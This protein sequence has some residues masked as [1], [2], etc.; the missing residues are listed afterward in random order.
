MGGRRTTV[1]VLGVAGVIAVAAVAVGVA[2]IV[3]FRTQFE[4]GLALIRRMNKAVFNPSALAT[5]GE[6][7]AGTSVVE[8]VG[9][10]SGSTYRTPIGVVESDAGYL[11]T[12]PYGTTADW[13]KNVLAAG[14][15]NLVHDGAT[16]RV[17]RPEVVP[18]SAVEGMLP[19]SEARNAR[20]FGIDRFLVLH[21][22]PVEPT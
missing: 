10:R 11:V 19:G 7:G 8:H 5:A 18:F 21:P 1:A 16:V 2:F 4:P 13:V 14:T 20:L 9:R 22:S 6:A 17:E 12:L 15:A 3:T